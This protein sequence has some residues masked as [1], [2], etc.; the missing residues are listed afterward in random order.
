M[1]GG[2]NIATP[3]NPLN[4]LKWTPTTDLKPEKLEPKDNPVKVAAWM[5]NFHS[6]FLSGSLHLAPHSVQ[7]AFFLGC[8]EAELAGRLRKRSTLAMPIFLPEGQQPIVGQ[9]GIPIPQSCMEVLKME[10]FKIT[11]EFS[12]HLAFH[13]SKQKEGH[14]VNQWADD[15]DRMA[16]ICD[17][18][19]LTED[20]VF[21]LKYYTG[22]TYKR[23][24]HLMLQ[25]PEPTKHRLRKLFDEYELNQTLVRDLKEHENPQSHTANAGKGKKSQ[26]KQTTSSSI[27]SNSKSA[28]N[29]NLNIIHVR[30]VGTQ[31]HPIIAPERTQPVL[32]VKRRGTKPTCATKRSRG[33]SR[34]PKPT[35]LVSPP[36]MQWT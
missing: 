31:T 2:P 32:S 9:H 21:V 13:R 17:V 27:S 14:R 4:M 1:D 10:F 30:D 5:N 19:N 16:E 26:S 29:K 20:D 11:P 23:L 8:M 12:R 6:Y 24:L 33:S 7:H 35:V 28:R 36:P 18:V 15:L 3:N 25:I 34:P 22:V